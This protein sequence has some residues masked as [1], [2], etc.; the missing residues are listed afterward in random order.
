MCFGSVVDG[1]RDELP[2]IERC[3]CDILKAYGLVEEPFR[4]SIIC[5]EFHL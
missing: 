5:V 1:A 2:L 3:G 4:W